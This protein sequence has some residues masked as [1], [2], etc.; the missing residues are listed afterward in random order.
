MNICT[1]SKISTENSQTW[2]RRNRGAKWTYAVEARNE[3]AEGWFMMGWLSGKW[4]WDSGTWSTPF[5]LR[6]RSDSSL[7]S[8]S[9]NSLPPPPISL[10]F[11]SKPHFPSILVFSYFPSIASRANYLL[12]VLMQVYAKFWY[13]DTDINEFHSSRYC[14]ELWLLAVHVIWPM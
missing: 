4:P 9:L 14:G 1:G 11:F 6:C 13:T 5:L 2:R 8:P 10:L 7:Q 3:D 12:R